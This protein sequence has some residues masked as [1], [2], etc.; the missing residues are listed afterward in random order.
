[1]KKSILMLAAGA[2]LLATP[3]CKKGENDPA[4]SLSSRKARISGEWNVTGQNGTST[5][6]SGNWSSSTTTSLSGST[7]TTTQST[8]N[9]GTTTSSTSTRTITDHSWVIEKDGTFSRTYN[10]TYTEE[11][12]DIWGLSTTTTTYTITSMQ[13]GTWSFVG[14]AKDAYKNKER[15]V[16]NVLSATETEN[17]AWETRLNSDNSLVDDGTSSSNSSDEVSSGEWTWTFDID[18][19]KGKEMV[20]MT[21][22]DGSNSNS[23]TTGSTT[24]TTTGT[25]TGSETWTLTAK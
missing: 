17:E 25:T 8:T 4:L 19:L 3:S 6:T 20:W 14:K 21:K 23:T 24:T 9:S 18:Q 2:L 1:M 12:E 7:L 10:Y 15:V 13:T 5:Y 22:G 11:E 16:F